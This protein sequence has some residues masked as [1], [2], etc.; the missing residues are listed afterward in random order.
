MA[1]PGNPAQAP[2]GLR[3]FDTQRLITETS[4]QAYYDQGYRCCIRYL[5]RDADLR[6]GHARNG[7]PDLSEAEGLAI[8]G[9]GM[10][11][12]AVQHPPAP[13]WS[14]TEALGTTWGANAAAYA[15][16]AGI[17]AGVN[18]WLDLEGIALATAHAD[19]IAYA[20]AW[21][22]AVAA[23]GFVPGV[24]VGYDVLLSPDELYHALETE[25]YWRACGD[26]PDISVRGY[27][28]RQTCLNIG[29][30][31]EFDYDDTQTDALGGRVI[32]LTTNPALAL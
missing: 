22:A 12:M 29:K 10:A 5:S 30:P 17:P 24:Y 3:G 8:L 9:A 20:N 7:T 15:A 31:D 14:P 16:D 4:A 1:L 28:L 19:I 32:W 2:A 13:G 18:I 23:A 26:I 21:F 27:Q 11:L 6:A 25:H